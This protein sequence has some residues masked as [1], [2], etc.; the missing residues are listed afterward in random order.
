VKAL[1]NENLSF[2]LVD[3]LRQR[4]P[5]SMHVR[6]LGLTGDDDERIWTIAKD[7]GFV[8]FSKDND[9]LARAL[10]RGH[11]PQVQIRMGNASTRRIADLLLQKAD[12]IEQ[13]IANNTESVF[14]LRP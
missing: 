11:P 5:G 8:I 12:D 1:L 10:V 9:F 6:D 3:V 7:D 13:F 14:L 4:F 2:R